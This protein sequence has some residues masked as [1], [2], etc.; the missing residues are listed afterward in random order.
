MPHTP[1]KDTDNEPAIQE[2]LRRVEEKVRR[3]LRLGG[4]TLDEIEEQSQDI[5]E[6]VKRI[7]EEESFQS[8]GTGY[9]GTH[10]T[11]CRGHC[12]RYAGL[13]ARQLITVS[14]IRWLKRAYYY[15][16]DCKGGWC[17]TDHALGLGRGQCSRKVQALI[18]RFSS[19]LPYR[20]VAQEMEII[21]GITLATSTV[22]RYAQ[23]LGQRLQEEWEQLEQVREADDLPAS[24]LSSGLRPSRLHVT[25]DGVTMDGVM[26]HVGGDWHEVKLGCVYQTNFVGKAVRTRYVATLCGHALSVREFRQASAG[27]GTSG[28]RRPLP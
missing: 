1:R 3:K 23:A 14:G 4:L 21:C 5:G 16:Q 25:M 12:A 6:E 24:A 26:V 28:R 20:I 7:I 9:G 15:C 10:Q 17:P 11:C 8:E 2:I 27:S 22:E 18:A 13:R 19:Y